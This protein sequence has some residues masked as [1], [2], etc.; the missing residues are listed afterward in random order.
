MKNMILVLF[1]LAL[2]SQ[3]AFSAEVI[4]SAEIKEAAK[5][6]A[7][8]AGLP[9]CNFG[10]PQPM[11]SHGSDAIGTIDGQCRHHVSEISVV[12]ENVSYRYTVPKYDTMEALDC[13]LASVEATE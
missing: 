5:A 9:E 7:K 1:G 6:A 4:C 11:V 13:S 8:N 3:A 12:T 10:D 2:S